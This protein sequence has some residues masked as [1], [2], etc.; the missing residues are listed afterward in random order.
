LGKDT[1]IIDSIIDRANY[2][3]HFYCKLK[4]FDR[5]QKKEKIIVKDNL[6]E[7]KMRKPLFCVWNN[8][9][10]QLREN[11]RILAIQNL[12]LS[13]EKIIPLF[14][15]ATQTVA[16]SLNISV[17][18]LGLL[19]EK[20]YQIKSVYGLSNL[21]L[22]NTIAKTRKINR[23]DAFATYVID[24]ESYLLIE[25]TLNDSFF[26]TAILTQHYGIVSYLGVPLTIFNGVCIGCLEVME[27]TARK[28]TSQEINFMI[29]TAR[30]CIAEYERN[31]LATSN[32]NISQY[33]HNAQ[34]INQKNL[35]TKVTN[36]L[37]SPSVIPQNNNNDQ[38][39]YI[40]LLSHQLLNRLTHKLSIPLTSVI[41]MSSVLKQEIYGKLNSKQLEYLQIIHDSGQ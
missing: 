38:E 26:S 9:S 16:N 24:S 23:N 18:C 17:S 21:G 39:K 31:L 34:N 15:E 20:E 3:N 4:R 36:I 37:S 32:N 33:L 22:M 29:I 12:N 41:G 5:P 40:K 2:F 27:T 6:L 1:G 14:E 13:L 19:L 28:F 11:K 25:N 35:T 30:W 10:I 8:E 7:I